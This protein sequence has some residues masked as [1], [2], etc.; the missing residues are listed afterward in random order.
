VNPT[1]PDATGRK[2]KINMLQ[3]DFLKELKESG[4][5]VNVFMINGIKLVGKVTNYD[6]FSIELTN[7]SPQIVFKRAISTVL[8]TI[9]YNRRAT[10]K[11][12]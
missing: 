6:Q 5:E 8:P 7:G 1:H 9:E 10:D 4:C 3:D 2:A 12:S 11:A